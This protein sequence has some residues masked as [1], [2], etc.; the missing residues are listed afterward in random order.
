MTLRAVP[1]RAARPVLPRV[2]AGLALG[3]VLAGTSGCGLTVFGHRADVTE[4]PLV[5][6]AVKLPD[7]VAG[8]RARMAEAPAE[9]FWPY[10]LG[11]LYAQADST[12]EAEAALRRALALDPAHAPSLALLSDLYFKAGRHDEAIRMLENAR[13]HAFP[14]GMPAALLEGLAL[15]YDAVD[16]VAD[17]RAALAAAP[18]SDAGRSARVYLELRG[19]AAGGADALAEEAAQRAPKSAVN[20]NNLGIARLRAGDPDGAEKAFTKAIDLD[21]SLPGP[22]YNLAILAKF[23]RFD[24]AAAARWFRAYRERANADP[25]G[26]AGVIGGEEARP[27]A[28]RKE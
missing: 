17:A 12:Q 27:I 20:Q 23:Y 2:L 25:D 24:D 8:T 15:H 1:I 26:L 16:R 10:R 6:V 3:A 21:A 5:P 7:D 28:E 18:A 9:P 22:Y 13:A 14:E 11:V 19:E 4:A